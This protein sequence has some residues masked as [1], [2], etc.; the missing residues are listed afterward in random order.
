MN[1]WKRINS[2]LLNRFT[3]FTI[4]MLIIFLIC[5]FGIMLALFATDLADSAGAHGHRHHLRRVARC[6]RRCGRS[7]CYL[8]TRRSL[9]PLDECRRVGSR[10]LPG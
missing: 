6:S 4:A 2:K 8:L 7:A 3:F 10:R 1:L 5:Q 9:A